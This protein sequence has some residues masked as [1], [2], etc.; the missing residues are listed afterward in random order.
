MFGYVTTKKRGSSYSARAEF[1]RSGFEPLESRLL[2]SVNFAQT[3][4]VTDDQTVLANLG[5]APAAR[6]DPNLVNPWGIALGTNSG[7]W[8]AENGTGTAESFDGGGQAI[9]PA[10]TIPGPGGTGTSAPTGVATNDTGGFV[11]SSGTGAGPA[12]ELFAT[13]DGTIAGWN[14]SVDPTHAVI[15]VD[16]SASGAVYK[17]LA[18]CFTT[19]GAFLYAT[20]F[21]AGTIDVFDSNFRPVRTPGG[22]KDSKI[23]KGFAHFGLSAINSHLY[24]T[25]AKQDADKHDDVAGAG[26]GFI[27]IFDTEGRL[28]SRFAGGGQ[29]N[30]PWGMAWA[31]FEGFG[32]FE[33]ALFVGNF[34][35]GSVNAF[36]FDSGAFLGKV[37]DA[38]NQPINIPGVW[39]LQFG[40]AVGTTNSSTLYF[41][42]GIDDEQHGLFGQLK[43]NPA[44]LPPPEGPTMTDPNLTVTT[45][46][47]G[48]DQP[49][50][51]AFLGPNDFLVLEKASGK[52]KHVVNGVVESTVL[53]LPVN[54]ASERGLLGIALQPD[55]A[56]THGVYL[57]W[58]ESE[59][60]AVSSD[61]N[62]V[63]VL[64]NRVDR[65]VW[66][67][68]A[69]SLT[70]DKNLIHLRSFQADANQPERGN[71]DAGKILFGPDSKLYFQIGDQGRRGQN[72]NL[73]NGAFGV[74]QSDDQFGGP[75]P[76]DAHNT[77]VIFRLNPDGTTPTD[78]PFFKVGAQMGGNVGA[79]IQTIYSYGH[80]NGFGL[81]FDPKTGFLWE[82]ENGDDAFDEMNRITAGSNGGWIQYMGPANRIGQLTQIESTFTPMQ[83]NLPQ[84]GNL[85]LSPV[86]PNTFIPALQQV[87]YSPERIAN[88]PGQ[89]RNQLVVL[90]GSHYSDPEFSWR[91]AVAPAAIGFAGDGL[92]PQHANDLFV[93][94]SRTFLDE[95]YLF[96]FK[97]DHS[98]RHF[99]FSDPT[100]R[101]RV[102]D[103]DYKFDEGQS[104]SLVAGKNFGI[105]TNIVTG[106]DGNLYVTSTSNGAVYKIANKDGN[107]SQGQPRDEG[108]SHNHGQFSQ[109]NLVSNIA[110][111]AQITDPNLKNPWG[112]S[113]SSASPFWVSNQGSNTSTLY[114]VTSAGVSK[115]PLTVAIPQTAAGP[116]GPTGQVFNNTTSFALN[117]K[118]ANFIF[119]DLNGTISAWNGGDT[120]TVEATN[121]GAVYTG[122]A[123]ATDAAGSSFLY[124]AD[125][126]HNRIDVFDGSFAPQTL[127]AG[128]FVD[129]LLKKHQNLVPFNVQDIDG[130][131]YV[132]YAPSG[133]TAQVEAKK[134][135]GAVAEFDS[136]GNFIRQ[137]VDGKR[138]A[139]PWGIT[140]APAGFGKFGGDL[141]VGNF[142]FN[143]GEISA[144]D[145][146]TGKFLGT[147]TDAAGKPIRNQA[148]WDIGFGNGGN[149]GNPNTLYFTAG[150]DGEADGLF[151]SIQPIG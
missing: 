30:S 131:I 77:G 146:T 57:Y 41:N 132:T 50:S 141:L 32:E 26:N 101:D 151:G 126:A 43:V 9:Q 149:G 28:L 18:E 7:L 83:G 134:G 11:I 52:V 80:R 117:G 1:R 15:A 8:V 58:T 147:L 51:M 113:E 46:V 65:Y 55:F 39:G 63:P 136:A 59:S 67:P 3:N 49:T 106:P 37:N 94:A 103:N 71:H 110:G 99:A 6:T 87:R 140:M 127:P 23:P 100:L 86:D 2:L 90:P 10:V 21:H 47:S 89:A 95:G 31:P 125:G 68:T 75:Q 14:N 128:A 25:Y 143:S 92:G 137:V 34:G 104:E 16:N 116:Q 66:D 45:V 138:L 109:T 144:F 123:I 97:F 91:W 33:N 36:D 118:P 84:G 150:I 64:G 54:N 82:S 98:R 19:K 93:G 5:L 79:N 78:N 88:S 148:L 107:Q 120:A 61:I 53:T 60:G 102:D 81:A 38:N 44:S 130:H 73:A 111:K 22:F 139:S 96:E 145:P 124:A 70:F 85:P 108:R 74:G 112:V 42:A 69:Q 122:L 13:E 135:Q 12:T 27:D 119:A 20:N 105:V 40:L 17:G 29:L 133:H 56:N 24:V 72:Q 115:V 48:L 114:S 35:D 62:D 121:P 4:L 76:D 129:P 142:A